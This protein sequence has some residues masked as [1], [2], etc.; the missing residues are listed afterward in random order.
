MNLQ[1][2]ALGFVVGFLLIDTIMNSIKFIFPLIVLLYVLY[3]EL[4]EDIK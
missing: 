1:I 3:C 4:K 2:G